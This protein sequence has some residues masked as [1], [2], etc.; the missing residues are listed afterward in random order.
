MREAERS[1]DAPHLVLMDVQ[2]L[3]VVSILNILSIQ[4]RNEFYASLIVE[5]A[6]VLMW[7]SQVFNPDVGGSDFSTLRRDQSDVIA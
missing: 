5:Y 1:R 4:L 7:R 3:P 2:H 6:E